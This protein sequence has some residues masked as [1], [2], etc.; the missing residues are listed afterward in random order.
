M[1]TE[2]YFEFSCFS[3]LRH[4]KGLSL[5]SACVFVKLAGGVVIFQKPDGTQFRFTV[6][7]EKNVNLMTL[8]S[9][10]KCICFTY[11]DM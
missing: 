8:K 4:Q 10:L 5:S 7:S 11:T 1:E 9:R 3:E 6:R 2:V